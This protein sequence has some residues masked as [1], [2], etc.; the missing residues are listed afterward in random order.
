MESILKK[1]RITKCLSQEALAALSNVSIKTIQRIENGQSKGSTYSIKQLASAL[2]VEPEDLQTND[3]V[4]LSRAEDAKSIVKLMNWSSLM[5][6]ILPFTNIILP[7]L[8]LRNNQ[9]DHLVTRLGKKIISVQILWTFISVV[10]VIL[11]SL[12]FLMFMEQGYAGGVPLFIPAYFFAIFV[13]IIIILTIAFLLSNK[14]EKDYWL[15][16][17]L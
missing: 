7:L 3:K 10:L 6:I 8:I 9:D 2:N 13:N 15:P 12:L 14:K 1:T 4:I 16:N 11:S 5:V 17:L